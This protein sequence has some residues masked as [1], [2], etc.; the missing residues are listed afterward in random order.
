MRLLLFYFSFVANGG[1]RR[2]RWA[3]HGCGKY[4]FYSHFP[5]AGRRNRADGCRLQRSC[6]LLAPACGGR[7]RHGGQE[8]GSAR[9]MCLCSLVIQSSIARA[10]NPS[11][12]CRSAFFCTRKS[13]GNLVFP[14]SVSQVFFE[15]VCVLRWEYCTR[16]GRTPPFKRQQ[17]GNTALTC[18]AARG[19][20]ECLQLL[21]ECGANKKAKNHV[22]NSCFSVCLGMFARSGP[23]EFR[24]RI[25]FGGLWSDLLQISVLNVYVLQFV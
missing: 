17:N 11:H 5:N 12:A 24:T 15:L 25:P 23:C 6:S 14:V 7:C 9:S 19:H 13:C 2:R 1:R 10:S 20:T 3:G 22:R 4:I 8:K 18:A 21:L 16:G